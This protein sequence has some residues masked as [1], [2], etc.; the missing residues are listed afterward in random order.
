MRHS[1]C[2]RNIFLREGEEMTP[3]HGRLELQHLWLLARLF[4]A[5]SHGEPPSWREYGKHNLHSFS[6]MYFLGF[7]SGKKT[8]DSGVTNISPLHSIGAAIHTAV[9]M[10]RSALRNMANPYA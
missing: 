7:H 4:L 2:L 6:Y 8:N 9:A 10:L 1:R 5:S 3:L